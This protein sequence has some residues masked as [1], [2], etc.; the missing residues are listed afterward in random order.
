MAERMDWT[1]AA[2]PM[3]RLDKLEVASVRTRITKAAC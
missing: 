3:G 2:I 1:A